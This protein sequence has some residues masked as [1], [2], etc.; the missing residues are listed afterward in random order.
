M[1]IAR[2]SLSAFAITASFVGANLFMSQPAQAATSCSGT[3]TA[4]YSGSYPG[5]GVVGELIV[6]YNSTN[7][8]TNS[9]CL[10]HRGA[11]SGVASDTFVRIEK[12]SQTSGEG[13]TC[14]RIGYDEDRGNYSSY[15]GPAGVTGT[16]NNCVAVRGWVEY[17]GTLVPVGSG[18]TVG[19]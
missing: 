1:S 10:Y 12:C 14:T 3:V 16:A 2:R 8:G 7:G 15:A 4:R 19:C 9:A 11:A 13:R 5:A 17:R 18:N 6:Y